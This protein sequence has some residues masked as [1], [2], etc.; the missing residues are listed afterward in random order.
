MAATPCP[1]F[2]YLFY[3][4]SLA[5]LLLLSFTRPFCYVVLLSLQ[6]SMSL[7]LH[8]FNTRNVFIVI[9]SMHI[10]QFTHLLTYGS[11]NFTLCVKQDRKSVV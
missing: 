4:F 8:C 1:L 3:V 11:Q 9:K 10:K 7:R 5:S 6:R 2:I